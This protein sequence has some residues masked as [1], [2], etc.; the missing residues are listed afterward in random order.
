MPN[1]IAYVVI[2]LWPF[3]ILFLI[4]RYGFKSG[5]LLSLLGSYMFLPAAFEINF[6]GIPAFDKFSL[7]SMTIIAYMFLTKKPFGISSFPPLLKLVLAGF[8]L[9]PFITAYTNPYPIT[10][11][12]GLTMYDGL[13]QVVNGFFVFFPFLL[14][15]HYFRTEED[16]KR[17]FKYFIIAGF[18]YAVLAFYEVRMSP[19]LHSTI[20][21]Y[22]PHS[23]LQQYRAGGFRAVLFMGHGLLVA[24]FLAITFAM[25][26]AMKK[27]RLRVFSISNGV[28]AFTIF[29]SLVFA[30]SFAA[31][32]FGLFCFFVLNFVPLKLIHKIT[33]VFALIFISYPFLSASKLFPHGELITLAS[34]ISNERASSLQFRF[35]N[36][37]SLLAK[38]NQKPIFGWGSWGRNR[39]Y[40]ESGR[41]TS[42]TDGNWIITIGTRGWFG[43]LAQFLFIVL[44]IFAAY[45]VSAKSKNMSKESAILL[46]THALVASIIL[47]DQM[48]NSSLNPLYWFFIGS[49]Y[50][51]ARFILLEEK[52]SKEL[53]SESSDAEIKRSV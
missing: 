47:L 13:S 28:L 53:S 11:L 9:S 19:Q 51:R 44:P 4:K 6:P 22:F 27:A 32:F 20:Y 31:L 12:P 36:E 14:G 3:I 10:G 38:A 2:V 50:G 29:I 39:V 26:T 25:I 23:F 17:I 1:I 18:I 42:V 45:R 49:L 48:P 33:V 52:K 37:T 8:I 41:D 24:L 46:A 40:A 7:T 30:K 16:Q 35:D 15:M 34:S 43:F 21:G 5:I